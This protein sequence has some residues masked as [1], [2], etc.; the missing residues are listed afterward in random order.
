MKFDDLKIELKTG[1]EDLKKLKQYSK[2][3][4][5]VRKRS[6]AQSSLYHEKWIYRHKHIVYCILRGRK[7]E[8]IERSC[9]VAPDF[10]WIER[11]LD[12]YRSKTVCVSA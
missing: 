2:T 7:Y 12:A 1:A 6:M 8:D 9:R 5:S 11:D 10:T 3:A 4:D